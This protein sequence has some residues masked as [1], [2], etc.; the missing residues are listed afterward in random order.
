MGDKTKVQMCPTFFAASPAQGFGGEHHRK[1]HVQLRATGRVYVWGPAS[2]Q[3]GAGAGCRAALGS[4]GLSQRFGLVAQD[5]VLLGRLGGPQGRDKLPSAILCNLFW[6]SV[7]SRQ[8]LRSATAP[9]FKGEETK[10][11]GSLENARA[12]LYSGSPGSKV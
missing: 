3:D 4:L 2:S 9:H 6:A 8:P 7:S 5:S 12:T 11:W 10:S 1:K